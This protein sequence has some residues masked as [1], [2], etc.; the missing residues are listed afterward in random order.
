MFHH[1]A[2][3]DVGKPAHDADI[4]IVG[5]GMSGTIA[6]AV[7]GRAGYTVL[8]IDRHATYP[9]D[10]RAEHL[11]GIQIEQLSRLGLLDGLT[12]GAARGET[13]AVGRLGRL[14]EIGCTVNFG[15][16]YDVMVNT[17]RRLL[18]PPVTAIH[19]RVVDGVATDTTQR[20]YLADGRMLTARLLIV[21]SGMGYSVC[22]KLGVT[23]RM[24][25]EAHS[26]TFGFNMIPLAAPAFEH[27]FVVY[28]G[29][30][31]ADRIDYLAIFTMGDQTRANLFT[32]GGYR[33]PWTAAFRIAPDRCLHAA[34][35]GL[36]K[37]IG[38]Y[39]VTGK[40]DV[41]TMDLYTSEGHRRDG[42]VLIGDAYQTSCPAAGT[43]ITRILTD[44]ERLCLYHIPQW[45]QTEGMGVAKIAAF[46]D[47]PVKRARDAQA[48]HDAE[49]RRSVSTETGLRW[50]IHRQQ[51]YV[52]RRVRAWATQ[53]I[54]VVRS[55]S[56]A[57][58]V[59]IG[60]HQS[61]GFHLG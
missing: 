31:L 16:P 44:I 17:A 2:Q 11:D 19:G 30:K 3:C 5:A 58:S 46:Y 49:Y 39:A 25:R 9:S 41:R 18:P 36:V 40:T 37:V 32:Y 7:L 45:L 35:P 23:R 20:V 50:K 24:V 51:V 38:D 60:G 29:E 22:R 4:I 47:D 54:N 42:V 28:Q 43:G 48:A 33:D 26:L 13:V 55:L 53:R 21:A 8:L 6:A 27:S 12:A 61:N 34:L 10:F 1:P 59:P 14:V 15:I 57:S 52:R 56:A